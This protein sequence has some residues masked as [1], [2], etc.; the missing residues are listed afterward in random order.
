V[1]FGKGSVGCAFCVEVVI[2]AA[3]AMVQ[4]V[5]RGN[6]QKLDTS[7]LHLAQQTCTLAARVFNPNTLEI[8]EGSHPSQ[9]QAI[10]VAG[11]REA[12]RAE[13]TVAM[14]SDSSDMKEA[15]ADFTL[16]TRL[17]KNK[18]ARAWGHEE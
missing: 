4:F 9:H 17:L 2:L 3:P 15:L 7:G 12:R 18:H 6:F 1:A 14:I 16:E 11:S 10:Y 13:D 8:A 5:G